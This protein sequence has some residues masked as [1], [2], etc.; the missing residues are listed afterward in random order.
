MSIKK[1]VNV[2]YGIDSMWR[3]EG[4]D[5]NDSYEVKRWD[6]MYSILSKLIKDNNYPKEFLK[7][8]NLPNFPKN[9][10]P[11]DKISFWLVNSISWELTINNDLYVLNIGNYMS[12]LPNDE[13][14]IHIGNPEKSIDKKEISNNTSEALK[15]LIEEIWP[16]SEELKNIY[17]VLGSFLKIEDFS[18]D[19]VINMRSKLNDD[20]KK[21]LWPKYKDDPKAQEAIEI[22][23]VIFLPEDTSVEKIVTTIS[24]AFDDKEI[25]QGI[26]LKLVKYLTKSFLPNMIAHVPTL[27]DVNISEIKK[28]EQLNHIYNTLKN[29]HWKIPSLDY[30]NELASY[31]GILYSPK[32]ENSKNAYI[33]TEVISEIMG[34]Y[35]PTR[36]FEKQEKIQKKLMKKYPK[37]NWIIEYQA[38]AD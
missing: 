4:I 28:D 31:Q 8:T 22:Y 24:K 26:K 38:P 17:N 33:L 34:N 18:K 32:Y 16:I 6:T 15:N 12:N 11:G 20:Y 37:Y 29:L 13:V 5:L 35:Y 19:E 25:P 7:L 30:Y 36:D 21:L 27:N 1:H 2:Y 3:N 14:V 10:K 9:I 23:N